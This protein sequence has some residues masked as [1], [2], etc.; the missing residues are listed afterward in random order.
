[1]GTRLA[2]VARFLQD[3]ANENSGGEDD[4]VGSHDLWEKLDFDLETGSSVHNSEYSEKERT[5]SGENQRI[6]RQ[7]MNSLAVVCVGSMVLDATL[8]L[9]LENCIAL[10]EV[11]LFSGNQVCFIVI[12]FCCFRSLDRG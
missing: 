4:E 7:D 11:V 1:M 8:I 6:R 5:G 10:E 2:A 9:L 3:W 12:I